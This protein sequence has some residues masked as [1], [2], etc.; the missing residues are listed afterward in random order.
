MSFIPD[1]VANEIIK[2]EI[3]NATN[4]KHQTLIGNQLLKNTFESS[5]YEN[6]NY[7]LHSSSLNMLMQKLQ[8][9]MCKKWRFSWN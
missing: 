5:Q 6:R 3:T 4:I 2:S 7:Q 8:A 1:C 9:Y